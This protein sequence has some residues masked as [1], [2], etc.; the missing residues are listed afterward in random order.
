MGPRAGLDGCKKSRSHRDS[1][2][3]VDRPITLSRPGKWQVRSKLSEGMRNAVRRL[4]HQSVASVQTELRSRCIQTRKRR[5]NEPMIANTKATLITTNET[6]PC[7]THTS[8]T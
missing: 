4:E 8:R 3:G 6:V 2:L 1:I 7:S 5:R